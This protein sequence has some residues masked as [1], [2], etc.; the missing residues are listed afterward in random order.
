MTHSEQL[1]WR[2]ED[3]R[4]KHIQEQKGSGDISQPPMIGFPG[5]CIIP[6]DCLHMRELI[7]GGRWWPALGCVRHLSLRTFGRWADGSGGA[8]LYLRLSGLPQVLHLVY[9]RYSAIFILA[10]KT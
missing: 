2:L 3:G 6:V 8:E 7:F 4:G 10:I 1:L 9:L 5:V